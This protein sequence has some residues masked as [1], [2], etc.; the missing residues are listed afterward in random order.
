MPLPEQYEKRRFTEKEM[1]I[2]LI[3]DRRRRAGQLCASHWHEHIEIHRVLSGEAEFVVGGKPFRLCAGNILIINSN[4][5]HS[6]A[7]ADGGYA[8]DVL[9]F[10]I[11]YISEELAQKNYRF[12]AL[13]P[14]DP[15]MSGLIFRVFEELAGRKEGYKQMCRALVQELLVYICRNYVEE[16]VPVRESARR[17]KE[18]E[19]LDAVLQYIDAHYADPL[20]N[21][22]LA[23]VM[24]LSEGRFDHL[25]GKSMGCPPRQYINDIRL[26]KAKKLLESHNMTTTEV[27]EMVGFRDYNHFG[28]L[29]RKKFGCTP[30]A[31]SCAETTEEAEQ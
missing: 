1:Q 21:A 30:S 13:I 29:F 27:A 10:D 31:V 28:R 26:E 2:Q 25:F 22:E 3:A 18:L 6:G 4:E 14:Q 5:L 15:A 19:R 7:C 20:P 24:C 23:E 17:K 12:R 8:S 9:I 11:G 16:I